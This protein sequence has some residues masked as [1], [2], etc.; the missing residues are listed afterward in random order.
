[1]M[2]KWLPKEGKLKD[3]NILNSEFVALLNQGAKKTIGQ[4]QG[5]ENSAP[6]SRSLRWDE[7]LG[8]IISEER[9]AYWRIPR[10]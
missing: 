1:M 4:T 8:K 3:V 9:N 10:R 7:E 5:S 6:K 2:K